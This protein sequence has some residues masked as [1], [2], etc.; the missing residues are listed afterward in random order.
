MIHL[1]YYSSVILSI[2]LLSITSYYIVQMRHN[3]GK[4][5]CEI[6]KVLILDLADLFGEIARSLFLDQ[7]DKN[8][9][10]SKRVQRKSESFLTIF[11]VSKFNNLKSGN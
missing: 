7:D 6:F 10:T 3:S 11:L 8:G 5:S 4:H 9:Q 1:L 2:I